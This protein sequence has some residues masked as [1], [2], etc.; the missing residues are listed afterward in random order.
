MIYATN[1]LVLGLVALVAIYIAAE[2]GFRFGVWHKKDGDV[3]TKTD[4]AALQASLLG[5]TALVLSFTF[6]I[7]AS[8]FEAR[9]ELVIEESN[10]IGTTYL[11]A[12]LVAEPQQREVVGLLRAYADAQIAFA[13]ARTDVDSLGTANSTIARLQMRL[14]SVAIA[15]SRQDTRSVPTGLFVQSL[16]NMI[17]LHEKR[18]Q[19]LENR[20]PTAV[21]YLVFALILVTFGL[22]GYGRGI[23]SR[24]NIVSTGIV[25]LL[26]VCV[27]ITILDM[28][29][30]R[31]GLIRV[32]QSS[33]VRLQEILEQAEQ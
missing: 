29:R 5:L 4:L 31:R 16:N 26:I 28:D 21:I 12:L 2:V 32:S 14:W 23:T 24:R 13:E 3:L 11:R 20:L 9:K 7:A 17:D 10:A 33:M 8:R 18:I 6:F 19:A 30:P 27:L 25:A 1:E 15:M 22:V